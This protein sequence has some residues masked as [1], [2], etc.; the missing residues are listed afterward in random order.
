MTLVPPTSSGADDASGETTGGLYDLRLFNF[1]TSDSQ[2]PAPTDGELDVRVRLV[3][4][5]W[6][7]V[8][9][10]EDGTE[11]WALDGSVPG[12]PMAA[13]ISVSLAQN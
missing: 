6:V 1:W 13:T 11:V 8:R 12:L 9:V 10:E 7:D 3:E 4:A 2:R 5:Q